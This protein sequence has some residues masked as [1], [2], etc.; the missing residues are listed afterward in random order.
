[1]KIYLK[2]KNNILKILYFKYKI[3]I[4]KIFSKIYYSLIYN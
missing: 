3:N 2:E 1:M 4:Y